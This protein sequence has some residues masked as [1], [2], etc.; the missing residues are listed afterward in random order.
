MIVNNL[1]TLGVVDPI[2]VTRATY[3]GVLGLEQLCRNDDT[4][5]TVA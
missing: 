1:L 3:H 2:F 5:L 4:G